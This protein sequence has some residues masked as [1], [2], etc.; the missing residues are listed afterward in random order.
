MTTAES[1]GRFTTIN[2]NILHQQHLNSQFSLVSCA[3]VNMNVD[4]RYVWV[5]GYTYEVVKTTDYAA[6]VALGKYYSSSRMR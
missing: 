5:M 3:I 4:N 2:S 1:S 6:G